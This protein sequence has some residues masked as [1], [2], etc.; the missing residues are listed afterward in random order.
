MKARNRLVLPLVAA[1]LALM[2]APALAGKPAS[3]PVPH[4]IVVPPGSGAQAGAKAQ[5][6]CPLGI[7]SASQAW[8]YVIYPPADE[9]RP[10][11]LLMRP[12]LR[13]VHHRR[14][15]EALLGGRL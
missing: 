5:T 15:L 11:R 4:A 9:Y 10:E 12:G 1:G 8:D 7:T 13:C 14:A 6:A 2:A 3:R